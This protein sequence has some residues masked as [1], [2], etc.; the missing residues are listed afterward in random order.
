MRTTI[1]LAFFAAALGALPLCAGVAP[2]A[3]RAEDPPAVPN[4]PGYQF[5]EKAAV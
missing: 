5:Y 1:R 3:A 4:D 2:S